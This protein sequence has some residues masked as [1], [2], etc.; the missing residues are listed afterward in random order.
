MSTDLKNAKKGTGSVF[1]EKVI[2]AAGGFERVEPL[3][4]P[5]DFKRRFFFGVPLT[6]PITKEKLTDDDLR[7]FIK[8]AVNQ[9]ELD[10]KLDVA[11]VIRRH[12]LPFDPNLY[13]QWMHMEVPNKPIQKVLKMSITSASYVQTGEP[14][15]SSKYPSGGHIYIIPNEWIEMGNATR[16]LLNV[17]PINP[18]FSSIGGTGAAI[19]SAGS[20]AMLLIGQ[21]GFVPAFWQLELL[22]GFC[23]E[24][25]QVPVIINECVGQ[26]A[27]MMLIDNLLPMFAIVSQSLNMD[28]LGQSVSNQ[29]YQVLQIKRGL[30]EK[31]YI[32]NVGKLKMMT[33]NKLFMGSV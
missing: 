14:N 24:D 19:S 2:D 20:A 29:T 5:Q 16:G 8:R 23:S 26:K 21:M 25:G 32:A 31:D 12:R 6:S 13:H 4:G 18:A 10:T 1:P 7:D 3:L 33:G 9:F 15:E 28:G 17:N 30:I 11:P 22:H 27:A